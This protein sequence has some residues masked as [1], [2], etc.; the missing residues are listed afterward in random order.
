[1]FFKK[2]DKVKKIDKKFHK[3]LIWA[4]IGSGIIWLGIF[5]QTKK[6]KTLFQ[7]IGNR[8]KWLWWFLRLGFEELKKSLKK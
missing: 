5:S 3:F 1:M 6:W 7:K 8:F 4:V 2:I